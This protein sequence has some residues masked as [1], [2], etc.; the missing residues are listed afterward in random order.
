MK[1]K[2]IATLL[3]LANVMSL[4]SCMSKPKTTSSPFDDDDEDLPRSNKPINEV[5]SVKSAQNTAWLR[6]GLIAGGSV[7]LTTG[8]V[9]AVMGS[10]DTTTE[11]DYDTFEEKTV[12]KGDGTK[13]GIGIAL[14]V[15]GTAGIVVGFCF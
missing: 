9:L 5:P 6:W 1:K 10:A 4:A 7:L 11:Y 2:I 3:I 8:I 14:S 12:D 15:I 13:L